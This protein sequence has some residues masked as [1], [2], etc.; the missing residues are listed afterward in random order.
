[1]KEIK[2]SE[3]KKVVKQE[4]KF[5][6]NA[7]KARAMQ[8]FLFESGFIKGLEHIHWILLKIEKGY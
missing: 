7:Q 3:L 4:I 6:K 1:M 2:I 5:H 8:G